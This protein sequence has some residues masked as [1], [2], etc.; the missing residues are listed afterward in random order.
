MLE[1]IEFIFYLKEFGYD[2]YLTSDT[3]PTRWDMRRMFEINS[4]LT[5]KIWKLLDTVGMDALRSMLDNED[6]PTT[7]HFIETNILGMKD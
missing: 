6:Y 1:Y 2:G 3:H 7:W 4:R 5:E